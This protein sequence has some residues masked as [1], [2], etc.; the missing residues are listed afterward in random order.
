MVCYENLEK[1]ELIELLEARDIEI[2][3]LS[4][5]ISRLLKDN[6]KLKKDF[7]ESLFG[8]GSKSY[9]PDLTLFTYDGKDITNDVW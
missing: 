7:D 5:S 3:I 6:L 9:S 4:V 8:L 2:E 1:Q